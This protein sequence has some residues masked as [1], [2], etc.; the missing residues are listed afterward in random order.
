MLIVLSPQIYASK[1]YTSSNQQ[2]RQEQ[3]TMEI[4]HTFVSNFR[5]QCS[6]ALGC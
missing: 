6:H 2:K 4:T 5:L 1:D 3:K